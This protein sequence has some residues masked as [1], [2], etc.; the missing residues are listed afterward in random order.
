MSS[1]LML[2]LKKWHLNSIRGRYVRTQT[3]SLLNGSEQEVTVFSGEKSLFIGQYTPLGTVI[4]H[5][6]VF[7]NERLLNYVLVHETAH[8]RQWWA[9]LRFPLA[10]LAITFAPGLLAAAFDPFVLGFAFQDWQQLV[11]LTLYELL[12]ITLILIP[13][14]FSWIMEIDADFQSIKMLGFKTVTDLTAPCQQPFR[15]TLNTV[16]KILTHP[17]IKLTLYLWQRFHPQTSESPII[18]SS[19]RSVIRAG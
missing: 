17:P 11:F 12:A 15:L 16:I 1:T 3:L 19:G 2:T 4:I 18:N 10:G 9:L 8:K 6:R 5:E 7:E 14:A 13:F